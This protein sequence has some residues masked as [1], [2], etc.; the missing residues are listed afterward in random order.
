VREQVVKNLY[1]LG[2]TI[3]EIAQTTG[4]SHATIAQDM[5]RLGGKKAFP[6]RPE[7]KDVFVGVFRR[8]AELAIRQ[9]PREYDE[10]KA[11]KSWLFGYE[12]LTFLEGVWQTTNVLINPAYPTERSNLARLLVNMFGISCQNRRHALDIWSDFLKG[13]ADGDIPAPEHK[14]GLKRALVEYALIEVRP[15]IMPIWD[16]EVFSEV[17]R[18]IECLSELDRKVIHEV[19]GIGCPRKTMKQI[20]DSLGLSRNYA[21]QIHNRALA[22]LRNRVHHALD[23]LVKPVGNALQVEL[24]QIRKEREFT[25][26]LARG[27]TDAY[28]NLLRPVEEL[29]LSVRSAN[30]LANARIIYIGQL[31]QRSEDDLLRV[32]DFGRKSLKEVKEILNSMGLSFGMTDQN[33]IIAKFN[34]TMKSHPVTGVQS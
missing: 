1:K 10:Q 27:E 15:N 24:Q 20:G 16:N 11:L 12:I 6:N 34:E 28:L 3:E 19:H 8:Y 18:Q 2:L 25:E 33:P 5:R 17:E 21:T 14:D 13:V 26:R 29:E 7:M 22:N 32:G 4:W 23:S 30:C 9:I 31:V